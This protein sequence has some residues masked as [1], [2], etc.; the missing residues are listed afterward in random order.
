MGRVLWLL[1][2]LVAARAGAIELQLFDG[3][4]TGSFDTT[5]T[6][7]VLLRVAER[8]DDLIGVINGGTAN[9]NNG[10][11]GN[12]NYGKGD[13][14]SAQM[15]VRHELLLDWRN[16]S[17]FGRVFYF[18]DP[19]IQSLATD[20]TPLPDIAKRRA[21]LRIQLLDAYITGDFS[22]WDKPLTVRLGNQ[23]INWGESTFI[24]NGINVINPIDVTALRVAGAELR[25]ALRPI[26][27]LDASIAL[28]E[29][30]SAEAFYQF[31]WQQT[32]LEPNG[33]YF[34]TTDIAS[35]GARYALL[36]FGRY[37][38]NPVPPPGTNLLP[39]PGVG[40]VIPRSPDH[41]A[42]ESG[43]WGLALRYFEPRLWGAEVGLYYV[44]YHSR[45]PL[46]SA[47]TGTADG[48]AGGDYAR[49]AEYFLEFPDD[50]DV[51]AGSFSGEIGNTGIAVQGELSYR[52]G[53][54]L[55]VDDVEL[56]FAGFTPLPVVGDIVSA[57]QIGVFGFDEY[58]RGWQRRNVLQPQMTITKVLGPTLGADQVVLLGE[59]GATLVSGM[60]EKS[61][62]R[63]EGPGT[64][65]SGNPFFTDI[66]LQPQ[67]QTNGFADKRSWG[68]R[69]VVRPTF[70][71]AIGA[72]NVVP[73]V[74]FQH[75]VEGTTPLPIA[76]FV[77]DRKAVT[78]SL[79]GIYL[80]RI[81]AEIGYTNFFDGGSFNLVKDR[82]FVS[83]AFSYSL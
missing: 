36:G 2:V 56:L 67:T 60:E 4:V 17:F 77:D 58:I 9:S 73:T 7:G 23:V 51:I 83:V 49:S 61:Q 65:T 75:D 5:V 80:D 63:Y 25:N 64:H 71:R 12:L 53:Q 68:Y 27:A 33:T 18:Y 30:F 62:L 59:I 52:F 34:S 3:T 82:D 40:T 35:P 43:Q 28:S 70:N 74:A 8:D 46:L 15:R 32:Y 79:A 47:I 55:Q 54:P 10:D 44:H 39:I 22:V 57:N 72:I 78:V 21:G 13:P 24:Q 1:P 19:V 14:T 20:R 48:L 38:D 16:F 31:L 50:I 29:H 69:L 41:E 26:P 66:M 6:G 37:P 76:N 45:L 81:T 42:Q 11:D